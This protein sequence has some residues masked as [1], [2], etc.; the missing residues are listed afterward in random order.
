[1]LHKGQKSRLPGDRGS[2]G[3]VSSSRTVFNWKSNGFLEYNRPV[4]L[5]KRQLGRALVVVNSL[6]RNLFLSCVTPIPLRRRASHFQSDRLQVLSSCKI[7]MSCFH[8]LF[9]PCMPHICPVAYLLCVEFGRP[10]FFFPIWSIP[11]SRSFGFLSL[12]PQR[13]IVALSCRGLSRS[14][15]TSRIN[16]LQFPKGIYIFSR[17]IFR[18]FSGS[19]RFG[20][21]DFIIPSLF[22][23][24]L[25]S[26]P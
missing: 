6:S 24:S 23:T 19:L 20:E 17:Y 21:Y 15:L 26:F 25:C 16:K 12:F 3:S 4:W 8:A 22:S 18:L 11:S 5:C 10:S 14:T 9:V 1:M 2:F 13:Y 7:R